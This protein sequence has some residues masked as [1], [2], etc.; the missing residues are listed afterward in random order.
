MLMVLLPVSIVVARLATPK[1]ALD[2]LLQPN[3]NAGYLIIVKT[4]EKQ[5]Y[6][7][8]IRKSNDTA[9]QLEWIN[10]TALTWPTATIYKIAKESIDIKSAVLIG[11]I[12]ARGTYRFN[13]P[14]NQPINQATDQLIL[15]DFIHQQIIDTITF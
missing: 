10:K 2:K 11:R 15:Y 3:T 6:T 13:L 9:Y 4:I 5:N 14:A 7:I 12:E 8:N 1:Q